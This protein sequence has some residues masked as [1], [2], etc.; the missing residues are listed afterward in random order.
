[1]SKEVYIAAVARTP[2]GSFGQ[3]LAS[4]SAPRLASHAIKDAIKKAGISPED[5]EEVYYGN[6]LTANVGQAPARQAALFSGISNTTPCTTVN[7]V[8]A[9]GSKSVMLGA[10]SIMLGDNDIVLT[11]GMESMSNAPYYLDKARTGYKLGHGQVTDGLVKDGLWDV[12][13]DYHMG[14]A[15]ESCAKEFSI[16]REEQDAYAIESY[17]RAEKATNEGAFK[18]EITPVEIQGRKE[19]ITISE[20]EEFRNIKLDK[21][22]KLKPAF[23]KD[24]TITAAN[25]STI[26]DG[27]AALVLMSGEKVKELGIKPIAK[28]KGF[29]DAAQEPEKFTIAPAKAIP[30]ALSKAGL[31]AKDVDYFE[32]NEAFSIVSLANNKL[33]ELDPKN[34]NVYGGAVSLGHPI[35]CSGARIL[36]TL[37]SVL[38]QKGGKIGAIGICNG[39][40]GASSIVIE[41]TAS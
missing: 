34:V 26:N 36:V 16:S 28:I 37:T 3:G 13:N 18:D 29:A 22:S 19:T 30:K 10:Q 1:M 14:N 41:N 38:K 23:Q 33:L 25:A 8:C 17:E 20:D 40:G 24:G 9:S 27:A 2:I 35:G 7:K 12:Y 6:V 15:G 31:T 39:G 11:G 32:I 5:I 21:V 4:L